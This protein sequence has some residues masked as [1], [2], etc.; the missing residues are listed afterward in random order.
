VNEK[1]AKQHQ[2]EH[3]Y[4]ILSAEKFVDIKSFIE[5]AKNY[6]KCQMDDQGKIAF[7]V[8]PT[9][10]PPSVNTPKNLSSNVPRPSAAIQP[11][12]QTIEL[13]EAS[14]IQG[15]AFTPKKKQV[16]FVQITDNRNS[17][18]SNMSKGFGGV[19]Q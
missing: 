10:A 8:T 7:L 6:G 12:V 14:V 17:V 4:K 13:D 3:H 18:I 15:P 1:Q 11:V 16:D 5:L 2:D 19:S 9:S